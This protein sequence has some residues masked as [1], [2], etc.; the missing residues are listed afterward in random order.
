ME[1]NINFFEVKNNLDVCGFFEVLYNLGYK[2][3]DDTFDEKEF[4][5]NNK[6]IIYREMMLW[7][8]YVKKLIN[9]LLL[10]S[11]FGKIDSKTFDEEKKH[12][13]EYTESLEYCY[14]HYNRF[15]DIFDIEEE[16][17]ISKSIYECTNFSLT[18]NTINYFYVLSVGNRGF[19]DAYSNLKRDVLAFK[20]YFNLSIEEIAKSPL[21]DTNIMKIRLLI[22]E[23][24]DMHKKVLNVANIYDS[25]LFAP[26]KEEKE[27]NGSLEEFMNMKKLTKVNEKN[28]NE[29]FNMMIK[30]SKYLDPNLKILAQEDLSKARFFDFEDGEP[31]LTIM[32]IVALAIGAILC[33]DQKEVYLAIAKLLSYP[34][35]TYIIGRTF[36][37][38][39]N[40]YS[41]KKYYLAKVLESELDIVSLIQSGEYVL[42]KEVLAL[43][44]LDK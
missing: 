13:I 10:A 16:N 1:K 28:V 41:D 3:E 5:F 19:N 40:A 26:S 33:K 7:P 32:T 6:K 30:Y 14:E 12:I 20:E 27:L 8:R 35:T 31:E 23:L 44:L 42:N 39:F 11:V 2:V 37:D 9:N 36:I 22:D 25:Y 17:D 34:I 29:I 15:H 43:K 24:N 21:G 18:L 4:F 38:K